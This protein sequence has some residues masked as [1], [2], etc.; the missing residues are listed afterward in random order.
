[1]PQSSPATFWPQPISSGNFADYCRAWTSHY[2]CTW[3]CAL[4]KVSFW[5]PQAGLDWHWSP[6]D[7]LRST[8]EIYLAVFGVTVPDGTLQ[9]CGGGCSV[10]MVELVT[11]IM[12]TMC[13]IPSGTSQEKLC[14]PW[15]HVLHLM[16]PPVNLNKP[17]FFFIQIGSGQS[18]RPPKNH[19]RELIKDY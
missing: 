2:Y 3:L 8:T 17:T 14:L 9:C 16:K 5:L 12:I 19:H 1:M 11:N 6:P 4:C 7:I 18:R 10:Y 15:N 13:T